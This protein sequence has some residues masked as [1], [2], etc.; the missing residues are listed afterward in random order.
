MEQTTLT[1]SKSWELDKI[2]RVCL[3]EKKDMRPLF[4]ELVADMLMD[5]AR[6]AV[7]IN[8]N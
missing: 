4:G 3:V 7:S 8:M 5:V 6:V 2:C 1:N